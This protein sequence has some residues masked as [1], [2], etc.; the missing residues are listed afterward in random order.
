[1]RQVLDGIMTEA[2]GILMCRRQCQRTGKGGLMVE[3]VEETKEI[4]EVDER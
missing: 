3:E 2:Q 4:K 1:M